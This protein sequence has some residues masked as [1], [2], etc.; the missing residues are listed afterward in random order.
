MVVVAVRGGMNFEDAQE[1]AQGEGE[2]LVLVGGVEYTGR[3]GTGK[4]NVDSHR[5]APVGLGENNRVGHRDRRAQDFG[6]ADVYNGLIGHFN[7][8]AGHGEIRDR[9]FQGYEDAIGIGPARALDQ[10]QGSGYRKRLDALGVGVGPHHFA[11][12][13]EDSFLVHDA[14]EENH[15]RLGDPSVGCRSNQHRAD[16]RGAERSSGIP[17]SFVHDPAPRLRTF[18]GLAPRFRRSA[19]VPQLTKLHDRRGERFCPPLAVQ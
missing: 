16:Q 12:G 8:P 9:N 3:N 14:A 5:G 10:L 13:D 6:A 18:H 15:P 7:R 17:L 2:I 1:L 4:A 19:V 11:F